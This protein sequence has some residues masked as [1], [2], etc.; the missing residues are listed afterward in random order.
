[1]DTTKSLNFT[2]GP[3]IEDGQK[4]TLTPQPGSGHEYISLFNVQVN[5][6][7]GA[8]SLRLK[9]D[10]PRDRGEVEVPFSFSYDSN[11]LFTIVDG[12]VEPMYAIP[13]S[14]GG[15]QYL[16]PN[17]VS[18]TSTYATYTTCAGKTCTTNPCTAHTGY[19]FTDSDGAQHQLP[20]AGVIPSLIQYCGTSQYEQPGTFVTYDSK[21]FAE[22]NG[23]SAPGGGYEGYDPPLTVSTRQGLLYEYPQGTNAYFLLGGKLDPAPLPPIIE[24]RNGNMLHTDPNSANTGFIV[25]DSIGRAILQFP[26]PGAAGATDTISVSSNPNPYYVTWKSTTE[27]FTLP[28]TQLIPYCVPNSPVPWTQAAIGSQTVVHSI[29]LPNQQS[30]VFY[31]GDDNPDSSLANPY[32]LLSEI[33]FPTGGWIKIHWKM[34]DQFVGATQAPGTIGGSTGTSVPCLYRYSVPVVSELDT[35]VQQG[36]AAILTQKYSYSTNWSGPLSSPWSQQGD[37][38]SYWSSKATT[39]VTTDNTTGKSFTKTYAYS[40]LLGAVN[41]PFVSTPYAPLIQFP[42]ETSVTTSPTGS[43]A[44]SSLT[45]ATTWATWLFPASE[46]DTYA[47]IN[48]TTTN[49][50]Y[51]QNMQVKEDDEYDFGATTASRETIYSYQ[52]FSGAPGVIFDLPCKIV[53]QDA[54]GTAYSE[55]DYLYDNSQTPCAAGQPSV[56]AVSGLP[57]NTHDE[58]LFGAAATTPRGNSTGITKKCNVQGTASCYDLTESRLFDET[59]QMTSRTI[60]NQTTSYSYSD[61]PQGGNP[62]GSS[63]AYVTSIT[64]PIVN[65]ISHITNAKYNYAIGRV[66]EIDDENQKPTNYEYNDPLLR[67]T[68]ADSPPDPNNGSARGTRQYFYSDAGPAPNIKTVLTMNASMVNTHVDVMDGLGNVTQTQDI[69]NDSSQTNYVDIGYDAFGRITSKSNPYFSSAGGTTLSTS[70][71]YDSLG[72]IVTQKAADSS[73]RQ[74]CYDGVPTDGQSNCNQRIGSSSVEW[75]DFQDER[76]N[77][78]QRATNAFGQMTTVVEP[79]GSG[80]VPAMGTNYTYDLLNNL[81][82]VTQ[83][84]GG[85]GSVG[86][87]TRSF[88]YDSISRLVCSSNPENS[89]SPCPS[90]ASASYAQ[91]TN[92]YTYD[93]YGNVASKTD[94]RSVITQYNYDA[95]NRLQRKS[96]SDSAT[97]VSCYEYDTSPFTSPSQTPNWVGRL[98]NAWTQPHGTTCSSAP[99]TG[100]YLSLKSILAYDVM[101][102][103]TNSQQQQCVSGKCT[104]GTPY[105]L[106]LGYDLAGNLTSFTNSVGSNGAPL[107]LTNSYDSAGRPCLTT[108]SWSLPDSSGNSTASMT[109]FQA[110]PSTATPGYAPHGV[111][112]NWFYGSNSASAASGCGT[113]PASTINLQQIF[114]PRLW[115]TNFT[116]SGQVP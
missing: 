4:T 17:V 113:A 61:S 11:S 69:G 57:K 13:L 108:S 91:G 116:A 93:A 42:A 82:S 38:R 65:G 107:T 47:G 102:R 56:S 24:D 97:P 60:G 85:S 16:Y 5:P 109:L 54:K 106:T 36:S 43:T 34:S 100:S 48:S 15:W 71:A 76:G 110:N 78:W 49:L 96:Y 44:S 73:V 10:F 87:R 104:A 23:T 50:I 29:E 1:V 81:T 59:G 35:G 30:Y 33:D 21:V 74:W 92:S 89:I 26:Y 66:S 9:P 20:V 98:T 14:Q 105:S 64:R 37:T 53:V 40:P 52:S 27:T 39:V 46:N 95:L 86:A 19:A 31:Y 99:N 72:R 70:Y 45:K 41:P 32:G 112:Q 67:L 25:T 83:S 28:N 94:A 3:Q 2:P 18:T 51:D 8:I 62:S 90:T 111:L 22:L 68:E 12:A 115:L 79:N 63:N 114:G 6:A 55:T 77:E 103:P 58:S 84:G 88:T 80:F 75:I 7:N 101:G